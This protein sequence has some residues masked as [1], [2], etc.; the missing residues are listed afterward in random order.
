MCIL[1]RFHNIAHYIVLWRCWLPLKLHNTLQLCFTIQLNGCLVSFCGL[2]LKVI[3]RLTAGAPDLS[4]HVRKIPRV[5]HGSKGPRVIHA[6]TCVPVDL[7]SSFGKWYTCCLY[8][9][10]NKSAIIAKAWDC[11]SQLV[12]SISVM[13]AEGLLWGGSITRDHSAALIIVYVLFRLVT[14]STMTN[15]L[16]Q[17]TTRQTWK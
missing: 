15:H 16:L 9:P 3:F 6:A 11:L 12:S 10:M 4:V 13:Q 1:V 14:Y 8:Y 17:W 2:T 7:L 5:L